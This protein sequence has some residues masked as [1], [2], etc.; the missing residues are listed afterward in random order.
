MV[1]VKALAAAAL[2][3]PAIAS[4]NR[5]S[6]VHFSFKS[7]R[8]TSIS[9]WDADAHANRDRFSPTYPQPPRF[10]QG[11]VGSEVDLLVDLT[12]TAL[13]L[14]APLAAAWHAMLAFEGLMNEA[15]TA[16]PAPV[17]PVKRRVPRTKASVYSVFYS[18]LLVAAEYSA[19]YSV[20]E[21]SKHYV[22]SISEQMQ[23]PAFLAL[24]VALAAG[25]K[26][27]LYG[28]DYATK[29]LRLPRPAAAIPDE[30]TH[31]I[32]VPRSFLGS[33]WPSAVVWMSHV[34][35]LL[36]V[37]QAVT[38][39]GVWENAGYQTSL[40]AI[41]LFL[42]QL[43]LSDLWLKT[44]KDQ[45]QFGYS[46]FLTVPWLATAIA[47]AYSFY[48]I[49]PTAGHMFLPSVFWALISSV[50]TYKYWKLNGRMPLYPVKWETPHYF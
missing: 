26:F 41:L 40:P 42:A 17:A 31:R 2:L 43:S 3:A 46:L 18:L 10:A 20:L 44:M 21:Y 36:A 16:A 29:I 33:T 47:A 48:E 23:S 11:K 25:S 24:W 30:L 35:E 4:A 28:A 45:R 9:H 7:R 12:K 38:A 15:S 19:L 5:F 49:S 27:L 50:M 13:M 32:Q 34:A 1:H 37:L 39:M 14:A 22:F 8:E 6:P